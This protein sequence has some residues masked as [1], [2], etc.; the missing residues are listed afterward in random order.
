MAIHEIR[1]EMREGGFS[2]GGEGVIGAILGAELTEAAGSPGDDAHFVLDSS[3]GYY[4]LP[5]TRVDQ[6]QQTN[7]MKTNSFD[8]FLHC[9]CS[10]VAGLW[11]SSCTGEAAPPCPF[12]GEADFAPSAGCFALENNSLL[13]VQALNGKISLPGGSA[14]PGEAAQCTAFRETWEETGLRLQPRERLAVFD[15]GFHLYRCERKAD[16][17]AI[18]PPPR[19]EVRAAFYLGP[20]QFGDY[21]W[22]FPDQEV[23]LVEMLKATSRPAD[24]HG[25]K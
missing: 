12:A 2:G 3:H 9:C 18:D 8:R 17:G 23:L 16:S 20:E 24:Y 11:L 21:E 13:L 4:R 19:M 15:T 6:H 5:S 14:E 25:P 22:R 10:A 7:F 1:M